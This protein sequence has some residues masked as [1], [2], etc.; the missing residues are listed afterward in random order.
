L[1]SCSP[2]KSIKASAIKKDNNLEYALQPDSIYRIS[3]IDSASKYA[4]REQKS[5]SRKLFLKGLDLLVNKSK[6]GESITYFKEA[7]YFYPDIKTYQHLFQAYIKS[8]EANLADS[9]NNIFYAKG[10]YSEA[11]FNLALIYAVKKDT[12]G[13]IGSLEEAAMAGFPFRE[14]IVKE[15]LFDFIKDRQSFQG[16]LLA[17]YGDDDVIRKKLFK[18][19]IK[20]FPDLQL[21]FQIPVDSVATINDDLYIDYDFSDFI[22]GMSEGRF[23]RDVT[24]GYAAVGKI[25]LD[26][27]V[28][29]IYK[30]FDAIA[31]TLN[32]VFTQMLVYDSLGNKL[33]QTPM[34]CFCSPL[35][36]KDL[37]IDKDLSIS[38]RVYQSVWESDPLEKGYAGNKIVSRKETALLEYGFIDGN[39]IMTKNKSEAIASSDK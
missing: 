25:A 13:C 39:R 3:A 2:D 26:N 30:T 35:E 27:G 37:L 7:I 23:S 6:P 14:R 1:P 34:S 12:L 29:I 20:S 38:V 16:F 15:P 24:N 31:D 8:G 22:P 33:S 9:V 4:S 11:E 17:N 10:D 18:S 19:F 28:A 36:S 21:P 32:P 5:Q